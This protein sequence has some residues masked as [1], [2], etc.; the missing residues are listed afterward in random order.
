MDCFK[1]EMNMNHTVGLSRKNVDDCFSSKF[2]YGL[3]RE[4]NTSYEII[5]LH[6]WSQL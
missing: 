1:N 6:I 3:L 4:Q 2:V 5:V